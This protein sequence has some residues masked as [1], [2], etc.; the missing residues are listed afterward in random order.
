MRSPHPLALTCPERPLLHLNQVSNHY[1]HFFFQFS[2]ASFTYNCLVNIILFVEQHLLKFTS[3]P[4]EG[5]L[6]IFSSRNTVHKTSNQ[7]YNDMQ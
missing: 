3:L 1:Y 6:H 2:D 5:F 4:L 7:Y